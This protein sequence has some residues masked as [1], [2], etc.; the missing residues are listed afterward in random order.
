MNLCF[1]I[2]I[3]SYSEGGLPE[4]DE[5]SVVDK[6]TLCMQDCYDGIH[7]IYP[8]TFG[9]A[10]FCLLHTMVHGELINFKF[11]PPPPK[12][13]LIA[14]YQKLHLKQ[15]L[16]KYQPRHRSHIH[17]T[18]AVSSSSS[19]SS[20]LSK[21]SNKKGKKG[22]SGNSAAIFNDADISNSN[23]SDGTDSGT[24][25]R[26]EPLSFA[27]VL[28]QSR[29]DTNM[30]AKDWQRASDH[31]LFYI[32]C[33]MHT[34]AKLQ[35]T[36][37][38]YVEEF[39]DVAN[40]HR[41]TQSEFDEMFPVPDIEIPESFCISFQQKIANQQQNNKKSK[42]SMK[43]KLKKPT[44][45]RQT[46]TQ[47]QAQAHNNHNNQNPNEMH[48]SQT[49]TES[50]SN[51]DTNNNNANNANTNT[52]NANANTKNNNHSKK[53]KLLVVSDIIPL[54]QRFSMRERNQMTGRQICHLIGEDVH[55]IAGQV[56][57]VWHFLL[58]FI[59]YCKRYLTAHLM[60]E[61]ESHFV[62]RWGACIFRETLTIRGRMRVVSTS[63]SEHE[64]VSRKVREQ[65]MLHQLD[66]PPLQDIRY[67]V[68]TK[69][70][71]VIFEQTY[72]LPDNRSNESRRLRVDQLQNN[73]HNNSNSGNILGRSASA[74][75][76]KKNRQKKDNKK[77]KKK[78]QQS[79]SSAFSRSPAIVKKFANAAA[80][81]FH[82]NRKKAVSFSISAS[83]SANASQKN[84]KKKQTKKS[85]T[86]N[87]LSAEAAE[88]VAA[89]IEIEKE[90]EK[91]EMNGTTL[92]NSSQAL[93]RALQ[94]KFLFFFF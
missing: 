91:S 72:N 56:F 24:G 33:L 23:N 18:A 59:P 21:A 38:S 10:H 30:T 93:N 7:A 54:F 11:I 15:Q 82:I 41:L 57:R 1:A 67:M 22:R 68:A 3:H 13:K 90:E 65:N 45:T 12:E 49:P 14:K 66:A 32:E 73:N 42:K 61:W 5:F 87:K 84:P 43:N 6:S 62:E 70:Q 80:Q 34:Y 52:N 76:M 51:S 46:Q 88:A 9:T 27:Q 4:L 44:F 92:H 86:K 53:K 74:S 71:A 31:H 17:I 60:S 69:D 35:Q 78:K 83:A 25:T 2:Y 75:N 28:Y 39:L 81:K 40:I 48:Q 77:T 20:S 94:S 50:N 37:H 55:K 16:A 19:S 36:I 58:S 47:A 63:L 89:A 29:I 26:G 79:S 64:M 85:Q 8:V